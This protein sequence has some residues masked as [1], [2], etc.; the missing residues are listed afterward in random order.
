MNRHL[1]LL[2][3]PSQPLPASTQSMLETLLALGQA[4]AQPAMFE[5]CLAEASGLATEAYAAL[6][7]LGDGGERDDACWWYAHPVHLTL[8]RDHFTLAHPAPLPLSD[9]HCAALM[10]D[11]NRHFAQDGLRFYRS[12]KGRWYLRTQEMPRLQTAMLAEAV[13]HDV[14]EF[15]PQGAD[16]GRWKGIQNE[17]QML[18]HEHPVNREREAQALPAVNSLWLCGQGR[19]TAHAGTSVYAAVYADHPF[20]RGLAIH[21]G[22]PLHALDDPGLAHDHPRDPGACALVVMEA[23]DATSMQRLQ[24][25]HD[26]LRRRQLRRLKLSLALRDQIVTAELSPLDLWKR[27]R[28]PKSLQSY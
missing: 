8:Q 5:P 15:Q 4:R 18:L 21:A 12:E 2:T 23:H 14:Q 19:L 20:A 10:A 25:M 3:D 28:R 1:Y 17:L 22:V 11:L 24:A 13:G 26:A 7:R 6:A 9:A 16:A 27:W